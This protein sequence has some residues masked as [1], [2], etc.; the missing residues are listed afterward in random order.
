ME[1]KG[2]KIMKNITFKTLIL[3]AII[4][5]AAFGQTVTLSTTTLGA[6]L[7]G[8]SS[9][10]PQNTTV[11]LAST[12]GM[13]ANGPNAQVN[14]V[15][16][17]DKEMMYVRTIPASGTVVVTR[18]AGTG[19]GARIVSHA[20]GATVYWGATQTLGSV[21]IPATALFSLVQPNAEVT[22]T[23]TATNELVLPKIYSFSG[24]IYSCYNGS[25]GGQWFLQSVGTFGTAGDSITQFCTGQLGSS[26]TNYI[27]NNTCATTA[28]G[29][30]QVMSTAGVLANMYVNAGTA[31][32]GGS[33]VDVVTL[34]K[35][36][37][38]TAITCTFATGGA[39]TQCSDVAHS[40][41]VV[42][43]D[44]ISWKIATA[45]SDTGKDLSVRIGKY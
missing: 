34:F 21:I 26:A 19:A 1:H 23:C 40:I 14:T 17:V 42:A 9:N 16:Y 6:A 2:N 11:T 32:S 31:V 33:S 45:S 13:L 20:N 38:S 35:N 29:V 24:D 15:L 7:G 18:G 28:A 5:T 30:A 3:L 4:A 10:A 43:G 37:S 39:A 41:T 22:G 36:G 27:G 12:T 44:Y 25:S 8:A